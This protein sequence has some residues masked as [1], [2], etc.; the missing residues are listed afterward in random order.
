VSRLVDWPLAAL[1][2]GGGA[3]GGLVGTRLTHA[4]ARRRRALTLVFFGIVIAVGLYVTIR[5]LMH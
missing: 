3:F 2:I 4:L 1:L 5:S